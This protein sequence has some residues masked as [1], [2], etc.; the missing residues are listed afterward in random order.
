MHNQLFAGDARPCRART[1]NM[2]R[3]S[4]PTDLSRRSEAMSEQNIYAVRAY[5]GQS[6]GGRRHENV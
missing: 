3:V 5:H 4:V 1:R 6:K 2:W